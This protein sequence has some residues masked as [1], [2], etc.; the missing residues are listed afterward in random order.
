MQEPRAAFGDTRGFLTERLGEHGL[1]AGARVLTHRLAE[2]GRRQLP[3]PEPD[4]VD[5]GPVTID[6]SP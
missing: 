2:R 5:C 6:V 1:E 4:N 3:G